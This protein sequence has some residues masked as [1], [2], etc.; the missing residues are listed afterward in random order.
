MSIWNVYQKLHWTQ[1]HNFDNISSFKEQLHI[2]TISKQLW[3][4]Q[5][6]HNRQMRCSQS[7]FNISLSY[8]LFKSLF[9]RSILIFR[10]SLSSTKLSTS[11]T[12]SSITLSK[13][14]KTIF[15]L[16]LSQLSNS[17]QK[18]HSSISQ[19]ETLTTTTT[20][21]IL[22][23]RLRLKTT[24]I[25]SKRYWKRQWTRRLISLRF[26]RWEIYWWCQMSWRDECNWSTMR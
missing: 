12:S 10:L 5:T 23:R 17:M 24:Y 21:S 22:K 20:S 26:I 25:S 3:K 8:A 13:S 1:A 4:W 15:S 11:S 19:Y 16:S 18:T 7:T 2:T 6:Q 9:S 14:L